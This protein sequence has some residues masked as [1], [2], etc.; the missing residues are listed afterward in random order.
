MHRQFHTTVEE[1]E[2]LYYSELFKS[3][4]DYQKA[5]SAAQILVSGKPD[6][7]LT[8]EEKQL[9]NDACQMWLEKHK[10]LTHLNQLLKKHPQVK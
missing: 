8:V 2:A 10:R 3:G 7:L 1:K 9:V 6:E 4:V 5:A